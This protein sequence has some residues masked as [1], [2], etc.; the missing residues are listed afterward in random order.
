MYN[1]VLAVF[2]VNKR[3]TAVRATKFQGLVVLVFSRIKT[4]LAYFTENLTFGTIVFVEIRQWSTTTGTMAILRDI[5]FATTIN[6]LNSIVIAFFV[7]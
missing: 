5:T 2:L 1:K 3:M 6:R 7:V 4:S